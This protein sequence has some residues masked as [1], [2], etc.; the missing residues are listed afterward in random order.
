MATDNTTAVSYI[1]NEAGMRSSALCALL[2]KLLSWCNQCQIVPRARHIQ[3][4]PNVIAD[5]LSRYWQA[6]QMERLLLQEVLQQLCSRWYRPQVDLFATRINH[7]LPRF[8]SPVLD[9]TAWKVDTLS[10]PW[11]DLVADAFPQCL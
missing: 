7:K 9:S 3:G 10:L 2:W 5:K 11:G 4:L 1:N 8:V 6:I